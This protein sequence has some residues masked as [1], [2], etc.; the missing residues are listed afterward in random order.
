MRYNR[1][2][3]SRR[4]SIYFS[5]YTALR[6]IN[7][8][9]NKRELILP[10]LQYPSLLPCQF[11]GEDFL[12]C[13]TAILSELQAIG[14]FLLRCLFVEPCATIRLEEWLDPGEEVIDVGRSACD[15]EVEMVARRR[16]SIHEH[17]TIFVV[18]SLI[19]HARSPHILYSPPLCCHICELE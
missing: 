14:P 11:I 17:D 6:I 2:F 13:K 18:F 8:S 10:H 1:F 3:I 12:Q 5:A 15:D 7:S 16:S 19:F 9:S 4:R